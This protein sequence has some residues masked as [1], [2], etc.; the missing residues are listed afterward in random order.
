MHI[1]LNEKGK[2]NVCLFVTSEIFFSL[3]G[4]NDPPAGPT[5]DPKTGLCRCHG[6]KESDFPAIKLSVFDIENYPGKSRRLIWIYYPS[7]F[8]GRCVIAK[9]FCDT[10][11]NFK[12]IESVN[13]L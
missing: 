4:G 5:V 1:S 7:S 9:L 13:F 6:Y 2:H 3:Q 8:V 12:S 10:R 11:R